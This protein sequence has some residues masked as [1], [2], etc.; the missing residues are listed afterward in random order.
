[1]LIC[2]SG[3]FCPS[4]ADDVAH[5]IAWN[6]YLQQFLLLWK[7]ILG[8]SQ[9]LKVSW[10]DGSDLFR[11]LLLLDWI[12]NRRKNQPDP[13]VQKAWPLVGSRLGFVNFMAW[14]GL[15]TTF[16]QVVV[17]GLGFTCFEHSQCSWAVPVIIWVTIVFPCHCWCEFMSQVD[18]TGRT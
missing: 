11:T 10:S 14:L 5:I 3:L 1:M 4:E 13:R 8:T 17:M 2:T 7:L 6:T 12:A 9:P 16:H 18:K 15:K